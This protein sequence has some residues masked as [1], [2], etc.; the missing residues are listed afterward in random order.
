MA[1]Q[2]GFLNSFVSGGGGPVGAWFTQSLL[3]SG[4]A[5]AA[6]VSS[7]VDQIQANQEAVQKHLRANIQN[8][9]S[10]TSAPPIIQLTSN[11]KEGVQKQVNP[12]SME[13]L[14]I[15]VVQTGNDRKS[16]EKADKVN[17]KNINLFKQL[18]KAV[19]QIALNTKNI[20]DQDT[21]IKK[22]SA[23]GGSGV[24]GDDK[25]RGI[26]SIFNGITDFLGEK[27]EEVGNGILDI[28]AKAINTIFWAVLGV[29]IIKSVVGLGLTILSAPLKI[30]RGAGKVIKMVGAIPILAIK[31][32]SSIKAAAWKTIKM[33]ASLPGKTWSAIKMIGSLPGK[34][35]DAIKKIGSL[36]G[37]AWESFKNFINPK[38]VPDI[39]KTPDIPAGNGTSNVSCSD[40]ILCKIKKGFILDYSPSNFNLLKRLG[41]DVWVFGGA[42]RDPVLINAR[43]ARSL[44]HEERKIKDLNDDE[45]SKKRDAERK[46]KNDWKPDP[47]V[48]RFLG[49]IG[50]SRAA[51]AIMAIGSAAFSIPALI[52]LSITAI[53]YGV[54]RLMGFENADM[55]EGAVGVFN[56]IIKYGG[57]LVSMLT[58]GIQWDNIANKITSMYDNFDKWLLEHTSDTVLGSVFALARG[59]TKGSVDL[60]K[61]IFITAPSEIFKVLNYFLLNPVYQGWKAMYEVWGAKSDQ[62]AAERNLDQKSVE[63]F[64]TLYSH[65]MITPSS[66]YPAA[67]KLWKKYK[68]KINIILDASKKGQW[69]PDRLVTVLD[70]LHKGI[71]TSIGELGFKNE[72]VELLIAAFENGGP[73]GSKDST[74]PPSTEKIDTRL[75]REKAAN[76][77]LRE[78]TKD[79]LLFTGDESDHIGKLKAELDTM[80]TKIFGPGHTA[81]AAENK[82]FS[83]LMATYFYYNGKPYSP[84]KSIVEATFNTAKEAA[85]KA[86]DSVKE[87][88]EEA[89]NNT[90]DIA[91]TTAEATVES[92]KNPKETLEAAVEAAEEKLALAYQKI[93]ELKATSGTA[94]K[95]ITEAEAS[96]E[97]AKEKLKA[98]QIA[99]GDKVAGMSNMDLDKLLLSLANKVNDAGD[100]VKNAVVGIAQGVDDNLGGNGGSKTA[101]GISSTENKTGLS[102][103]DR[104]KIKN[105]MGKRESKNNYSAQNRFGYTGKYQFGVSSLTHCGIMNSSS[106]TSKAAMANPNNWNKGYS[107]QRWVTDA[108]LQESVMD[109]YLNINAKTLG[110]NKS[111]SSSAAHIGGM[112]CAAHLLGAGGARSAYNG[113]NKKAYDANGATFK[114]YYNIGVRAIDSGSSEAIGGSMDGAPGGGDGSVIGGAINLF[115]SLG[116]YVY[117]MISTTLGGSSSGGS[118]GGSGG[119]A[120]L[121]SSGGVGSGSGGGG[122]G[123]YSGKSLDGLTP[124]TRE[125][126][127]ELNRK[128]G[129]TFAIVSAYRAPAYNEK[130]GGASKSLHMSGK[131]IDI[132]WPSQDQASKI[133]FIQTAREI[134]FGGIGIYPNFIHID[135]GNIRAWGANGKSATLPDWARSALANATVTQTMPAVGGGNTADSTFI[136]GVGMVSNKSNTMNNIN[137]TLNELQLQVSTIQSDLLNE[138]EL[139]LK[140]EGKDGFWGLIPAP[141]CSR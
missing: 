8:R 122:G 68:D 77:G 28:I 91:K 4:R 116:Q 43:R 95:V 98:A 75:A 10:K 22:A 59:F 118:G 35:W 84:E 26:G 90:I 83:E 55:V 85:K 7:R 54:A 9:D 32:I 50:L 57:N 11:L 2:R 123:S 73:A 69:K 62:A 129:G 89:K 34:A 110:F 101:K 121:T 24:G 40:E 29:S 117:D 104:Q 107:F 109:M 25:K 96:V 80:Y 15:T 78:W 3:W 113:T 64:K 134:G 41:L 49:L 51:P 18:N 119:G 20:S 45:D 132:S 27:V 131:A 1:Y 52:G 37:K 5:D 111:N 53:G 30:L 112:L 130:I 21:S 19:E 79:V 88:T 93:G 36:P 127:N 139:Q 46:K 126:L 38:Y 33:V 100:K 39:P 48:M 13:N 108:D 71:R 47:L 138:K 76:T 66:N 97:L 67:Y 81:T 16:I 135:T 42:F 44:D 70:V 12:F 14:N 99:A 63:N 31:A 58:G 140:K 6:R 124:D 17:K 56:T 92:A 103:A 23:T 115:G 74:I 94:D 120:L 133:L 102:D 128:I 137:T 65:N 125:K 87:M 106:K 105:A 61:F 82:E 141:S 60:F 86:M 114:E 72:M 136:P